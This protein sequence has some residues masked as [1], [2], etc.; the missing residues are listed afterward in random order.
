MCGDIESKPITPVIHRAQQ[1]QQLQLGIHRV[2]YALHRLHQCRQ[3]CVWP[4]CV[5]DEDIV[6]ADNTV[7]VALLDALNKADIKSAEVVTIYQGADVN[8]D[9]TEK[10]IEEINNKYPGKQI[11]TVQ[12]GQPYYNYI[13]SLE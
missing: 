13:V 1:P 8:G 2:A 9:E 6:V 10:I 3:T 4:R 5:H 12:G 11:E 7:S